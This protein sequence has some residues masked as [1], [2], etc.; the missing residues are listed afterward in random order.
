[1]AGS[2][3]SKLLPRFLSE[4]LELV[5]ALAAFVDFHRLWHARITSVVHGTE[6][7]IAITALVRG[8]STQRR[9]TIPVPQAKRKPGRLPSAIPSET[10]WSKHRPNTQQRIRSAR[11]RGNLPRTRA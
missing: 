9:L 8:K 6:S 4:E 3:G 5:T 7:A 10:P 1:M 2:A 11:P